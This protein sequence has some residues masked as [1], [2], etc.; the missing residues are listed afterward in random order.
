MKCSRFRFTLIELL[1]V[2]AI[3]AILASM[4]LPALSK[5]REKA[6]SI[7]CLGNLKQI[8]LSASTYVEDSNGDVCPSNLAVGKHPVSGYNKPVYWPGML[9]LYSGLN[10]LT[11]ECPSLPER[12]RIGN[13]SA[14]RLQVATSL[15]ESLQWSCYGQNRCFDLKPG[16]YYYGVSGKYDKVVKPSRSIFHADTYCG[17]VATRGYFSLFDSFIDFSTY[18]G[19]ASGRHRGYVNL[20]FADGHAEAVN[21]RAGQFVL[22][23][24]SAFCPAKL[25]LLDRHKFW[26]DR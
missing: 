9:I 23:Y 18:Q 19:A 8:S 11:F 26:L 20:S 15:H 13:F 22:S 14:G 16:L 7:T 25:G 24:T 4:L 1:V 3:I 12:Y 10:G 17:A 5:A 21:G 2:I 6:Q